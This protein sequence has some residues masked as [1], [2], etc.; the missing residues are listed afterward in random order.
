KSNDDNSL[1]RKRSPTFERERSWLTG[2]LARPTGRL[3]SGSR[4]VLHLGQ[5]RELTPYASFARNGRRS[6]RK[7]R[8]ASAASR[9]PGE[10]APGVGGQLGR[11]RRGGEPDDGRRQA[12][13]ERVGDD[14]EDDRRVERERLD[15]H[16]RGDRRVGLHR[17]RG[18]G[19]LQPAREAVDL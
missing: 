7:R 16:A 5:V 17:E 13:R 11:R 18:R 8:R 6:E 9:E 3:D 2:R 1:F 19:P 12:D 15:V 10:V 14:L 4:N